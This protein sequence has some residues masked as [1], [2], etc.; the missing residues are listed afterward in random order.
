MSL[1]ASLLSVL[2]G[3]LSSMWLRV[4]PCSALT[5]FFF[6]FFLYDAV[7]PLRIRVFKALKG[8][9]NP[10]LGFHWGGPGKKKYHQ[11]KQ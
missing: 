10:S 8:S 11:E 4:E 7:C 1:L 6:F 3:T 5:C 2:W 9:N